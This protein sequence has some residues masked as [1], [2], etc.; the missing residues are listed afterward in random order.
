MKFFEKMRNEMR[1]P[2]LLISLA[3]LTDNK[4]VSNGDIVQ[5]FL[6]LGSVLNISDIY[7]RTN[8]KQEINVYTKHDFP[9][10]LVSDYINMNSLQSVSTIKGVSGIDLSS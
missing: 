8:S 4:C 3:F 5:A 9:N 7:S 1:H 2:N 6:V 10:Q